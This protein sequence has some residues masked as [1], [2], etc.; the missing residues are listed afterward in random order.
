LKFEAPSFPFS[1]PQRR[2]NSLSMISFQTS[3][4]FFSQWFSQYRAKFSPNVEWR[5]TSLSPLDFPPTFEIRSSSSSVHSHFFLFP[6]SLRSEL[7]LLPPPPLEA[8][9][10]PPS[11]QEFLKGEDLQVNRPIDF[12]FLGITLHVSQTDVPRNFPFL[13]PFCLQVFSCRPSYWPW[14]GYCPLQRLMLFG[15]KFFLIF[16]VTCVVFPM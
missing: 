7:D 4:L 6:Q 10:P 8:F 16:K 3:F 14:N 5:R 1:T 15:W 9:P 11:Q 13:Y 2:S 12:S